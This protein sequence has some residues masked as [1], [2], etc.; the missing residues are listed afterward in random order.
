M[1]RRSYNTEDWVGA[2]EVWLVTKG[3]QVTY[4]RH[5]QAGSNRLLYFIWSSSNWFR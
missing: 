5:L 3:S 2:G 1:S 4:R